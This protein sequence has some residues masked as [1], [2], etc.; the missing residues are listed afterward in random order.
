[1]GFLKNLCG[2]N[3]AAMQLLVEERGGGDGD[4]RLPPAVMLRVM[5]PLV[6]DSWYECGKA[7]LLPSR[8]VPLL[9]WRCRGTRLLPMGHDGLSMA[10]LAPRGCDGARGGMMEFPLPPDLIMLPKIGRA[11]VT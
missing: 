11:S 5:Q 7:V 8:L 1:M 4:G 10:L 3:Y 6:E 2:G 9:P